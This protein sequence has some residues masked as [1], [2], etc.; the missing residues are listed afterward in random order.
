MSFERYMQIYDGGEKG[1]T[2]RPHGRIGIF[3]F[4]LEKKEDT[5]YRLFTVGETEQYYFWKDEPDSQFLY[6]SLT[7]ALDT[8]HAVRDR[9]CLDFSCKRVERYLK[10]VYKKVM[11]PPVLSYLHMVAPP[12]TWELGVTVTTK[13]LRFLR[14]GFLQMRMDVRLKKEGVDP[15][16]VAGKP[17]LSYI[18]PIPEGTC[19][20]EHMTLPVEIPA[21]A[22]HVGVFL[23]GTGYSGKCYFEQPTLGADGQNLLPSF[24][25]SVAD[26]PH[27]EWVGQFISRKEWP[28]FRVCLNGKEIYKGEIFERCHRRSEWEI[29]LPAELLGAKNEVTYELIS[30]YHDPLPYTLYEVGVI[31]QP[32]AALSLLSVS[33]VAPA[34]G[35]ARVLVRTKRRETAVTVQCHS[36]QLSG[37][38]E[39]YT[40]HTPGLHGILLDCGEPCFDA[41]FTLTGEGFSV[42][43]AVERIV[44]RTADKVITGTGDM[45]YIC[46]NHADMEEYLSWYLSNHVGDFITVRPVYRWSGTRILNPAV[47]YRF[48]KLMRELGMKYVLMADGREVPG[49]SAQPQTDLLGGEGFLGVQLHERDGAQYYWGTWRQ[50]TAT[51][52]MVGDLFAFAFDEDPDH[53][54][55]EHSAA[56]HYYNNDAFRNIYADRHMPAD[57]RLAHEQSVASLAR[58]RRPW[59]TRHTGP[60]CLFGAMAE[61][62]YSWLGAE[63]MYSTMEPLM[64][65]LRGV[66]KERKMPTYGVHHAVQWS[67]SPHESPARYRRYRLALYASYML[68]ATDINTEEGLWRMEEYYEAHHRFGTACNAHLKQQQDFYTYVSTHSRTGSFYSPAALLHGRDDGVHFFGKNNIWGVRRPFGDAEH[69]WQLL[70]TVYPKSKPNS[71]VYRHGCPEDVPQGY[72]SGTPLGSLD[73]ISAAATA[74]LWRDYRGLAF[75]GYNRCEAEDAERMRSYVQYGGKL[76]L[77]M[78]HLTVTSDMDAVAA[79]RLEF[80]ENVLKL[81]NGMPKFR[82]TTY[83]G[84]GIS[85]CENAK[86]PDEV[87]AVTDDGAPLCGRYRMGKGTLTVF[88]TNAYPAH[89]AIAEDYGKA[90][91]ALLREVNAVEPV[92]VECGDDVEFA[93][94]RQKDGTKHIYFLAV[95]WYRDPDGVRHADLRLGDTHYDV[96]LPFGVML[97]C[98]TDGK[99]AVWAKSEDGEILTLSDGVTVQGVGQV[100]FCVAENGTVTE[101]VVD[102]SAAPVQT[103]GI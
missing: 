37:R 85:V 33:K 43:G 17:D 53:T 11:W 12:T 68:G 90:L 80:E 19:R 34:G 35:K 86:T 48:R 81:C 70:K 45:V 44:E 36:P 62:G 78:A 61:A 30:D 76:L 41:R 24:N 51:Q 39:T 65:F 92:W 27:L 93:V 100:T 69:S 101:K 67:S 58:M 63:T 84:V 47:W 98:V 54:S 25:E 26:R 55:S 96:T 23:E 103:L 6:R 16:S 10:R 5:R 74:S 75:L 89:A 71:A 56:L 32:D 28:E 40:F 3:R 73:I 8:E 46:Q 38:R 64:G 2:I 42:E 66:A 91:E 97:K 22:A 31:E 99:R 14:G 7:D 102:F 15:R 50:S 88:L 29:E 94:Y 49:L 21:D 87:L 13:N 82:Q 60:S 18:I 83:N 95:D 1:T 9:Y 57:Y 72:H 59:D 79:G 20:A 52:E 77:S 4:D